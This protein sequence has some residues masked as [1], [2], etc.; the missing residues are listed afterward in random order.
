MNKILRMAFVAAIAWMS[1]NTFAQSSEV[2]FSLN[3]MINNG[4]TNGQ[5]LNGV[6]FEQKSADV[7]IGFE[8]G[9][10][11]SDPIYT[12]YTNSSNVKSNVVQLNVGNVLTLTSKT[13]TFTKIVFT[14]TAKSKAPT[15][16][17]Y[18][19]TNGDYTE[20]GYTWTGRTSNFTLKN[21]SNKGGIQLTTVKI[22]LEDGVTDGI[23]SVYTIDL[24]NGGKVYD[25]NGN[26]VGKG[27]DSIH[28]SGVYVVNGK[29]TMIKK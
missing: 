7:T 17:N 23:E 29:K 1:A 8:T 24:K 18:E 20:N 16:T 21:V 22:T 5:N 13:K 27:I 15:G 28:K 25:I 12:E 19:M 4:W 2:T 26:Y 6:T 3:R 11:E 14:P 10:G 9:T